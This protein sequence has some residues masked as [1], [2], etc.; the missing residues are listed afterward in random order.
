MEERLEPC[1]RLPVKIDLGCGPKKVP[2]SIGVDIV[3]SPAVDVVADFSQGL[4]FRDNSADAVYAYHLLEHLDDFLGFMG[5]IW[6]ICRPD[7]RVYIKVPHASSSYVTWKDPTHKRGMFIATFAYFDDTYFDGVDFAYYVKARFR[8]EKARL[9]FSIDNSWGF[10]VPRRILGHLVHIV[11]NR[12]R[13]SQFVCERFWGHLVGI[14]EAVLVL[15][16]LKE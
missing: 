14:E 4:P 13:D 16:A 10:P 11:A 6:R 3:P 2:G 7:G 15:R 9:N 1:P 5:D 8:I 12:D